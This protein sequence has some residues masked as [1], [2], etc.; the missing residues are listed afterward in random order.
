ML[1]ILVH[2]TSLFEGLGVTLHRVACFHDGSW[3]WM[4]RV[5]GIEAVPAAATPAPPPPPTSTATTTTSRM[6][7]AATTTTD[8][9]NYNYNNNSTTTTTAATEQPDLRSVLPSSGIGTPSDAAE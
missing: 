4:F 7:P 2:F 6:L 9:Y 5:L 1:P 3:A 8:Y